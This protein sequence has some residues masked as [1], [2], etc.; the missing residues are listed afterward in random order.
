[1][2]FPPGTRGFLYYH[3]GTTPLGGGL[4][5]R[6][7]PDAFR[8]PSPKSAF[9][10]GHDLLAPTGLPWGLRLP[11]LALPRHTPL[12]AALVREGLV[13]PAHVARISEAFGGH[14]PPPRTIFSF[15][16]VFPVD[17][18][19]AETSLNVVGGE[20]PAMHVQLRTFQ[21]TLATTG[22]DPETLTSFYAY[23]GEAL[24]RLERATSPWHTA[25]GRRVV[26][27]RIVKLLTPVECVV[28][29]D[30]VAKYCAIRMLEPQ[31]GELLRVSLSGQEATAWEVDID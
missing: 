2:P 21:S 17:F 18:Q 14:A 30:A 6:V 1:R 7:T 23:T 10:S 5:F 29:F 11:E 19:T 31:E 4:R 9:A 26:H 22:K 25:T 28:D 8:S 27:L 16:D 15:Q 12:L 3:H 24:A 20:G 13:E